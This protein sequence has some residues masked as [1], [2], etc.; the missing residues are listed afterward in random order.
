MRTITIVSEY[1]APPEQ[2]WPVVISFDAL[3]DVMK[4]SISY[5]GLPSGEPHQGQSVEVRLSMWGWLPMGTWSM[6]IVERDDA[7]FR[8]RSA[9]GG[10]AVT[11][12]DHTIQLEALPGAR[13]RH[14]DTIDIEA[15]LMTPLY[16]LYGTRMYTARQRARAQLF[17]GAA[18]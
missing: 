10:G 1:D 18:A 7:A 13:T 4:S 6:R 8:M 3:Q 9:E 2:A 15:G 11:T 14:T 5:M 17:K 16:V 12:W